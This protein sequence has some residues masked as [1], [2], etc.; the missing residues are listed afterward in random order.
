[1]ANLTLLVENA[2]ILPVELGVIAKRI[3]Y[4]FHSKNTILTARKYKRQFAESNLIIAILIKCLG[5]IGQ[6]IVDP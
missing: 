5:I 6:C 4:Y 3:A 1:M 2:N